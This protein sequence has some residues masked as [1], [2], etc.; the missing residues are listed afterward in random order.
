[1]KLL[2]MFWFGLLVSNSKLA[3][4]R[5]IFKLLLNE[6]FNLK[7]KNTVACIF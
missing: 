7:L 5:A 2:A 1:M 4:F 3:N 6:K